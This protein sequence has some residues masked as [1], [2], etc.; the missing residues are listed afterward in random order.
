MPAQEWDIEKL[1][2]MININLVGALNVLDIILP[3]FISRDKGHLVLRAV[4]PVTVD[5][6]GHLGTD[7]LRRQSQT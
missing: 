2:K 1:T 3:E 6:Q 4:W 7:L 5:C